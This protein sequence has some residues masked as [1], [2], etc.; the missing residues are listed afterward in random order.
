MQTSTGY[1]LVVS[2]SSKLYVSFTKKRRKK[3]NNAK[4]SHFITPTDFGNS[5]VKKE[6]VKLNFSVIHCC[7]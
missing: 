3:N 7:H 2:V 1:V 6:V 5:K 4:S